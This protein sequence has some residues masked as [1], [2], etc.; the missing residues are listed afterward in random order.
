MNELPP[1]MA[2]AF[3]AQQQAAAS[4]RMHLPPISQDAGFIRWA[5]DKTEIRQLLEHDLRGDRLNPNAGP[6]EN[7]WI[8]AEEPNFNEVGIA[9]MI[10][11]LDSCSGRIAEFTQYTPE[12]VQ[13]ILGELADDITHDIYMHDKD[14]GLKHVSVMEKTVAY[15]TNVARDIY[16]AAMNGKLRDTFSKVHH[17]H[18]SSIIQKQ[19][20]PQQKTKRW[21]FF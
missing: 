19:D 11:W 4:A 18:E 10:G 2:A 8:I 6:G 5:L 14:Y 20:A 3:A 16:N 1:E 9:A 7:P 13:K 15:I 21:G 12:Q 17:E